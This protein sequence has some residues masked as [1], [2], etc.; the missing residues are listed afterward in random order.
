MKECF[1]ERKRGYPYSMLSSVYFHKYITREVN[2]LQC[3]M[4]T[5]ARALFKQV[6]QF[7]FYTS[8]IMK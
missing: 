3:T 1:L 8:D 5:Y 6:S 4:A 2:I 7:T